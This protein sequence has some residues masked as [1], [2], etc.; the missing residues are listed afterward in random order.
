MLDDPIVGPQR[1]AAGVQS[2]N[3]PQVING[4]VQTASPF[5]LAAGGSAALNAPRLAT[6]IG[7]GVGLPL[8]AAGTK[9]GQ[10]G[11]QSAGIGPEGQ[12]LAGT[13]TGL[14]TGLLAGGV[15]SALSKA[16]GIGQ[17]PLSDLTPGRIAARRAPIP[18]NIMGNTLS[19]PQADT[20]FTLKLPQIIQDVKRGEML[21]GKQITDPRS[22]VTA[23]KAAQAELMSALEDHKENAR[24]SGETMP[25]ADIKAAKIAA[26]PQGLAL[27]DP[28]EY[29]RQVKDINGI[30]PG[31]SSL[32]VDQVFDNARLNNA[33]M[34]AFNQGKT[35]PQ[36]AK[37]ISNAA[38]AAT[39]KAEGDAYRQWI[40][41]RMGSVASDL[42]QRYGNLKQFSQYT[43]NVINR[44][45]AQKPA[46][47]MA[48]L[49][50]DIKD[51]VPL[52]TSKKGLLDFAR[53]KLAG[54]PTTIDDAFRS[55]FQNVTPTGNPLRPNLTPFRIT[56]PPDTSGPVWKAAQPQQLALPPASSQIGVSGVTVPDITARSTRGQRTPVGL[57]S[58]KGGSPLVLDQ[59][60]FPVR[61]ERLN[62]MKG[63]L[64]P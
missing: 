51:A 37:L 49:L 40:A 63:L 43:E 60:G 21:S 30:F 25:V 17:I 19:V 12:E 33:E 62:S 46:T 61:P 56:A 47:E 55:A 11:A 16:F 2:G 32:N 8:G 18:A 4:V 57:F 23:V 24:R 36:N 48:G 34:S 54:T 9:L 3:I 59:F 50:G 53:S 5:M 39:L 1:V 58:P 64:E 15:T 20:Q 38:D 41:Q 14:G 45:E 22:A 6:A 26:L 10:Y 31:Q 27:R 29:A 13:V 7:L 35:I 28:A 44:A 42:N 52:S